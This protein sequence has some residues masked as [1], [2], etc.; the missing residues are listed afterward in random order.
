[1]VVL[2]HIRQAGLTIPLF[3]TKLSTHPNRLHKIYLF[4]SSLGVNLDV[5]ILERHLPNF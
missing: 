5:A 1:M 3:P 2:V 4:P